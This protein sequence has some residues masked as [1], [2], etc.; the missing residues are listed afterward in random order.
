MWVQRTPYSAAQFHSNPRDRM[1]IIQIDPQHEGARQADDTN[2][3]QGRG[4]T[5]FGNGPEIRHNF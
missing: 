1:G 4:Y 3:P 5:H 2:E